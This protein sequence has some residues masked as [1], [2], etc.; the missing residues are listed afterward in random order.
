[1]LAF[2]ERRNLP[3]N[4][5]AFPAWIEREDRDPLHCTVKDMTIRGARVYAPDTALPDEFVLLL[6]EKCRVKRR[7]KVVWREIFTAGVQFVG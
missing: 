2:P 7:C 4:L 6:D 3:R 1:M 5:L